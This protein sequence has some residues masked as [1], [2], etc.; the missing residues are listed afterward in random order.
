M[1][2][3][4]NIA[5]AIKAVY[6]CLSDEVSRIIFDSRLSY[7]MSGDKSY[8]R[9]M[10]DLIDHLG[11]K[12]HNTVIDLIKNKSLHKSKI[13]V[14]G[15]GV[16]SGG[17]VDMLVESGI[18]ISFLCDSDKSKQGFQNFGLQIISPDELA[19]NHK[20]AIIVIS[21]G[22]FAE[23][24]LQS[25][26]LMGFNAEKIYIPNNFNEI[27]FGEKFLR[28]VEDEVYVDSGAYNG[29][30]IKRFLGFCGEK[31]KRI[32][33]FEPDTDNYN[34]LE[35][36]LQINNVHLIK[37]GTWN[38]SDT[39]LF[40]SSGMGSNVNEAGELKIEVTAIDEIVKNDAVTFIKMDIEGRSYALYKVRK[41]Q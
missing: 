7:F 31:Y 14:Y 10:L 34:L 19:E 16:S 12:N 40:D 30:T 41:I 9:R 26:L 3:V 11:E 8:L 17:V 28:A 13:I 22:F 15:A 38:K 2:T 35:K 36:N 24:I 1:D 33:A 32:Y 37:K 27:Y 23:E 4:E 21:S 5:R 6:S 20:D 18:N 29:D 39:L 25:L